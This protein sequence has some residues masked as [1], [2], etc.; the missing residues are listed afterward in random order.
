MWLSQM[1]SDELL[2]FGIFVDLCAGQRLMSGVFLS[3]SPILFLRQDLT[4]PE[5]H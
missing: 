3:S 2:L 5:A 4:G 1:E